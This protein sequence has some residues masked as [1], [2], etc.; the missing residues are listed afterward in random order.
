MG[1]GPM[2]V[3][4]TCL[5]VVRNQRLL[6]SLEARQ[7]ENERRAARGLSPKSRKRRRRTIADLV[8]TSANAPP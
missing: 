6:A 4:L 2:T 7:A 1:L 3:M 5:F 8:T